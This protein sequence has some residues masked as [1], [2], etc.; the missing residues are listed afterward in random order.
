MARRSIR[1]IENI[2]SNVEGVKKLSDRVI[3][4]GPFGMGLDAMLTWVP[5][6][7]TAY[8]VGTGGWLMLQA[9][10]AK[11]TP[12]TLA[13]MGAYMAI[14]T[15]T[16]TVPIAGD[17]VDTFFPGQLMAARALQKHIESTHWVEDTEANAR[18]TGDH[19]MHKA[20]VQND[21]TLKRII[22]L[23]D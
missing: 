18:A 12:A 9:V 16:G 14:D 17:I 10:R 22:Y 11:A 13:R 5:V 1:D 4:I 15:A 6:V 3:G 19:E 23:H 20:R 7:G 8:T 2:W 21:K